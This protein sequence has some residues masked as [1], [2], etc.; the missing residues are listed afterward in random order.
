[1]EVYVSV[2]DAFGSPIK[3]PA[4]VWVELYE[5][6]PRSARPKGERIDEWLD[7]DLTDSTE[8]NK[9]W[10]DLL[11]AYQFDFPTQAARDR[12]YILEVT[13]LCSGGKRLSAEHTLKSGQ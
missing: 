4:T 2:L 10:R 6:A 13:C 3:T 5:Y 7:I 11:R 12:P 8:N 1:M 9:R